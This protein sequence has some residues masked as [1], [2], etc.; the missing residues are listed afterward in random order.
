M[1]GLA[2]R[3]PITFFDEP[4]LGLDA[5]AR[6]YFYDVLLREYQRHPRTIVISTHL[7]DEMDR[8]LERVVILDRGRVVR[9][10]DVEELRGAAHQVTGRAAAV[11]GYLAGR[12]VLSLSLIHI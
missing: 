2:S 5:T 3:A 4:Y 11:D 7:I 10:A 8:L 9:D 6:G 1:L 12:T